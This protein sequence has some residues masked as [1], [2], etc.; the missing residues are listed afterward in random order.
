[1]TGPEVWAVGLCAMALCLAAGASTAPAV[2]EDS[3]GDAIGR[4]A[5]RLGACFLVM[6]GW[7]GLL[8]G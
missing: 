2:D 4:H 7:I 1:M 6:L 8:M 3:I 5:L